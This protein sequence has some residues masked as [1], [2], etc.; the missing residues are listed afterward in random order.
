MQN[1]NETRFWRYFSQMI[2]VYGEKIEGKGEDAC[3]GIVNEKGAL[4]GC[5][6]GCG[7]I[8]SRRY[9][10]FT[11]HTGAYVAS[12]VTAGVVRKWFLYGCRADAPDTRSPEK[13]AHELQNALKECKKREKAESSL[14]GSLAKEFPTTLAVITADVGRA[15]FY[16]A[17]D[18]RGYVLDETGLHQ[19]TTDDVRQQDAMLNIRDDG[20]LKNVI[21]AAESFEIHKREIVL[22]G[23]GILLT[24]TDGCFGYLDSPMAFEMLLLETL[25]Q[26]QSAIMWEKMIKKRIGEITGDDYTLQAMMLGY[27]D[28]R[29]MKECFGPR[30]CRMRER[31]S[32]V[33]DDEKLLEWWEEY[34]KNYEKY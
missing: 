18:S 17:G 1:I 4:I 15:S 14:K 7:G 30:Y 9:D 5:F 24:C 22:C 19:I 28:F 8:G 26:A 27:R 23:H 34:K 33:S 25:E 32:K 12:R 11:G 10:A 6:D 29:Q 13:L 16:W 20:P 2:N 3:L 21:S 31:F